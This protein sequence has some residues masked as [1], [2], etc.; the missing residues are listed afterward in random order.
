METALQP[1]VIT[2][3]DLT[4]P[5]T[6]TEIELER[7]VWALRYQLLYQFNR[8]PWVEHGYCQPIGDV[9]LLARGETPPPGT[10]HAELLDTIDVGGAVGF[11]EN[12]AF[13]KSTPGTAPEKASERSARGFRA[14]APELPLMKIGV[15]TAKSDGIPPSE[16]LSHEALESAVDPRVANEQHIRKYLRSA[17]RQWYIGEICDA[18]QSRGYDVGLPEGRPCNVPEAIVSDF[19]NPAWWEQQQTRSF[20][21]FCEEAGLAPRLEPWEIG[22]GG[23][24]S[25]APEA[26]PANWKQSF[27]AAV[28]PSP[29]TSSASPQDRRRS[30]HEHRRLLELLE[31]IDRKVSH[32]EDVLAGIAAD[33]AEL[34]S[35]VPKLVERDEATSKKLGEFEA[36]IAAGEVVPAGEVETLKTGLDQSIKSLKGLLPAEQEQPKP[37][38]LTKTGYLYTPGEGVSPDTRFSESGLETPP[39]AAVPAVPAVPA[40]PATGAAEQP[41][42]PEQPAKAAVPVLYFSGDASPGEANGA[43]VPGYSE[44]TGPVQVVPAA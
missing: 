2:V 25:T 28:P 33:E 24:M 38:E 8:S 6:Y 9:K 3:Q 41:E 18:S 10:W 14:D 5:G 13:R 21:T 31:T 16:V 17:T 15:Q 32:M 27:G 42:Q 39:V 37:A 26:E 40:D 22:P 36:K 20:T 7:M 30:G 34:A 43:S 1:I 11:H 19:C 4:T 29:S 44:Y 23:Y 12:Q 35:I